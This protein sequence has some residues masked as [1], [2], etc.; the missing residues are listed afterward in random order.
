MK[1]DLPGF[2]KFFLPF[3]LFLFILQYAVV[4]FLMNLQL[5]YSTYSI[6]VFHLLAT[7]SVY[8]FVVF[9]HKS[10]PDKSGFAFMGASFFKMVAAVFFLLPM[11][12][13]DGP[14]KFAEVVAFFIP[15][16]LFLIFE[17]FFVVKIINQK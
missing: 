4:N 8:A 11:L 9:V 12:L 5:Y 10:F 17:T 14:S 13:S 1:Q 15:Y 6:Y 16:F 2:L 7:F 3:I